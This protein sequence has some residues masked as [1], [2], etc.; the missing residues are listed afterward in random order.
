MVEKETSETWAWFIEQL[1]SDLCMEDGLGWSLVR[2]MQK[3]CKIVNNL[4]RI[5]FAE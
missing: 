2:D 4:T 3:V 5:L 1:Q